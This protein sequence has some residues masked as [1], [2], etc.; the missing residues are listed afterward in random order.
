MQGT[1]SPASGRGV[2]NAVIAAAA[3]PLGGCAEVDIR[4][5]SEPSAGTVVTS[6]SGVV[7][8]VLVVLVL[9]LVLVS[10]PRTNQLPA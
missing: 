10:Q 3:L 1:L 4:I 9:V 2:A 7:V 5:T 8:V 6:G